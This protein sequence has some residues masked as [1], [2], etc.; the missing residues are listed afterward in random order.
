M[1]TDR[2]LDVFVGVQPD[3][4]L[5]AATEKAIQDSVNRIRGMFGA[6]QNQS[7]AAAQNAANI[8]NG[9]NAGRGAGGAAG[10]GGGRGG[11]TGL[12]PEFEQARRLTQDLQQ[13]LQIVGRVI[14]ATGAEK[15][16]N[17]LQQMTDFLRRIQ[18]DVGRQRTDNDIMGVR[19][20]IDLLQDFR[21]QLNALLTR[22]G[23]SVIANRDFETLRD[24]AKKAIFEEKVRSRLADSLIVG[25]PSGDLK[26]NILETRAIVQAL[27]RDLLKAQ[28]GFDGTQKS[29][30]DLGTA[31]AKFKLGA[32]GLSDLQAQAKEAGPSFNT[33]TNNSYQ[34]GQAIEDFAVGYSLNGFAGGVR[35]AA[36][37]V[38]FLLNNL[39]QADYIQ[40]RI[41]DKWKNLLPVIFGVGSAVLVTVVPAVAEWLAALNDIESKFRSIDREVQRIQ[42]DQ[43]GLSSINASAEA[44]RE[45]ARNATDVSDVVRKVIDLRGQMMLLEEEIIGTS[46]SLQQNNVFKTFSADIGAFEVKIRDVLSAYQQN[47]KFLGQLPGSPQAELTDPVERFLRF[48]QQ[49]LETQKQGFL[50]AGALQANAT[51]LAVIQKQAEAVDGLTEKLLRGRKAIEEVQKQSQQGFVSESAIVEARDALRDLTDVAETVSDETSVLREALDITDETAK[52]FSETVGTLSGAM[53]DLGQKSQELAQSARSIEDAIAFSSRAVRQQTEDLKLQLAVQQ[54]T[55]SANSDMFRQMQRAAEESERQLST[56]E[57]LTQI[58]NRDTGRPLLS[59]DLALPFI[60]AERENRALSDRIQLQQRINETKDQLKS[61][62]EAIAN[63]TK[64]SLRDEQSRLV[65]LESFTQQLQANALSSFKAEEQKEQERRE[66]ITK[67]ILERQKLIDSMDRLNQAYNAA[68][69]PERLGRINMRTDRFS[70]EPV[71]AFKG[72]DYARAWMEPILRQ[73]VLEQSSTKT[74][75]IRKDTTPRAQ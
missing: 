43:A 32:A 41:S 29:V 64:Q 7:A 62:E 69:D 1:S 58:T 60:A 21:Q 5:L 9:I 6:M 17:S 71:G 44:V 65:T 49:R 18:T 47:I 12:V 68:G 16:T 57:R 45:F 59:P 34:L 72:Q 20:S 28:E 11:Q 10:G 33:L 52:G 14:R 37:N 30:T 55:V 67:E 56:I 31:I 51:E 50:G 61:R 70:V 36:N 42:Q 48:R 54:G 75:V 3:A 24:E 38:A 15:L 66:A 46:R 13:E 40:G 26:K 35:G 27:E 23:V 22:S 19:Q 73:M 63:L 53:D 74:E 2:L 39:V 8:L 25:N 4:Q